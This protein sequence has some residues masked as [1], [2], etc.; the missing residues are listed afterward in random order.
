[1]QDYGK[2]VVAIPFQYLVTDRLAEKDSSKWVTKIY[3]PIYY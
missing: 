3:Q 1:M 2:S